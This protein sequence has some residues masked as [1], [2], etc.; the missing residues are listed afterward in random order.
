MKKLT[1]FVLVLSVVLSLAACG[2]APQ[3]S[4]SVEPSPEASSSPSANPSDE[5]SPEPSAEPLDEKELYWQDKVL[6]PSGGDLM[7]DAARWVR[8]YYM[9][10]S[11]SEVPEEQRIDPEIAAAR[12]QYID[13]DRFVLYTECYFYRSNR[14]DFF[15]DEYAEI[16]SA[17]EYF[18][19]RSVYFEF[20]AV[21]GGYR[22]GG[23]TEPQ[24]GDW[25][26]SM[27]TTVVRDG[28]V[29]SEVEND[30][31]V[32]ESLIGAI[33][34]D[35]SLTETPADA[36]LIGSFSYDFMG[37]SSR[38]DF[39][40][41]K[42]HQGRDSTIAKCADNGE[43]VV[44]NY[45]AERLLYMPAPQE[46]IDLIEQMEPEP[47]MLS[48]DGGY[49]YTSQEEA[50]GLLSALK[51]ALQNGRVRMNNVYRD[52]VML[53]GNHI[54]LK[55]LND[56]FG[57][58]SITFKGS[59]EDPS[60]Q[61]AV[62][63]GVCDLTV[64]GADRVVEEARKL[65]KSKLD[66]LRSGTLLSEV[67]DW[68]VLTPTEE[69]EMLRRAYDLYGIFDMNGLTGD[70]GAAYI[71]RNGFFYSDLTSLNDPTADSLYA[72]L[73]SYADFAAYTH[74]VFCSEFAEQQLA[75]GTYIEGPGGELYGAGF[76][77]GG[78]NPSVG[79]TLAYYKFEPAEGVMVVR[80]IHEHCVDVGEWGEFRY[81]PDGESAWDTVFVWE[82]GKWK[83]CN[84][85]FD[86]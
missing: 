84:I 86:V 63:T 74:E 29:I 79:N 26:F 9:S 12:I 82:D 59:L 39:Y 30:E 43:T 20:E 78:V 41:C 60:P 48:D 65:Y 25:D 47:I 28:E 50:K 71:E 34:N 64:D 81:E 49:F 36:Q 11:G 76:G 3:P 68:V 45:G 80:K 58:L 33:A 6:K 66:T 73:G 31:W 67:E 56:T 16:N 2:D 8:D 54:Y 83:V 75:R 38:W 52:A 62:M 53:S 27:N 5:P 77:R 69:T 14:N 32:L 37:L 55:S 13:D 19:L 44:L 46:L 70:D 7:V 21:Q 42:L 72:H 22:Y 15:M 57:Y 40:S 85:Q 23:I 61:I 10:F 1:V 24:P 17:N 51:D 35:E 4:P 18:A